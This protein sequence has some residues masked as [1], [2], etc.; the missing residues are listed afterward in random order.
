MGAAVVVVV[1]I[2]VVSTSTSTTA[3][4][5]SRSSSS[6]RYVLAQIVAFPF[7]C[8]GEDSS[9]SF[10]EYY[11]SAMVLGSDSE[12]LFYNNCKC[13]ENCGDKVCTWRPKRDQHV[14]CERDPTPG[15]NYCMQCKCSYECCIRPRVAR[16]P[17]NRLYC[18]FHGKL[19]SSKSAS[20]EL[21]AVARQGHD[22]VLR[23]LTPQV[24]HRGRGSEFA[25]H[26]RV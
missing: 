26:V 15:S 9:S 2:V 19:E 6:S 8:L 23:V 7:P 11:A 18:C 20:W 13:S 17:A 22:L 16:E 3:S 5:R 21:K 24:P 14:D 12:S 25:W 10:Y 4:C 1:E